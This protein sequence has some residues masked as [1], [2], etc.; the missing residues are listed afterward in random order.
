MPGLN[1]TTILRAIESG[2]ITGTKD[3]FGEWQIERAGLH[4]TPSTVVQTWARKGLCP[5][6]GIFRTAPGALGVG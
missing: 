4:P 3:L 5:S 1:K 6:A 2:K